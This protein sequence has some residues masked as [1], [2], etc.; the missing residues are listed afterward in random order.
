MSWWKKLLKRSKG[1]GHEPSGGCNH[2]EIHLRQGTAEFEWFVS[3]GELEMRGDLAHGARHLANLLSFD[4][5]NPEWIDLLER[6]LAAGQPDP[7]QLIPRGEKAYYTSEAMRAYLWYRQGRLADACELLVQVTH[8][9]QDSRYLEA[10]ALGWLEPPGV[11]ESLPEELGLMLFS[12]A[13]GRFPEA[14]LSPV[15]R[16]QEIRRWARLCD[17]FAR[18]YPGEGMTGML[19]A[20]LFRKAGYFAEAEALVR[21]ALQRAPDWHLATALGLILRQKGDLSGAEQAFSYALQLD[22]TDMSARLEAGDT[23]FERE[24]W[25]D[26]LCWYENALALDQR[27]EWAYPSALFCRWMLTEDERQ[28]REL[29]DLARK[30]NG[31]AQQ[32]YNQL[33][34]NAL[35]EPADATAN[36]LRQIREMLLKEP[37]KGEGSTMS[38]TVS[39]LEAPSNTLAFRLEMEALQQ[40]LRLDV[41]VEKVAQP[42]P[43][44]SI[45]EIKY[46]LWKYDG[47]DPSP[48]LPPPGPDV[49]R[50]ITELARMPYD[51]DA[52]WAAA[53]HVAEALGPARVAEILA[54]MVHPPAVPEGATALAWL[55]RVQ[56]AA[57]YAAAQVDAG[58]DG[59]VRRE[60]LFSVLLGPQ[61]WSTEAA[62]RALTRIARENETY[63]PAMGEAFQQLADHRP[64]GGYCWWEHTLYQCWLELPHLFP[65]E[66][67]ELQKK[68]K[69]IQAE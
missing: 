59:S 60:A 4:P 52:C 34:F 29:L 57:M 8:A 36:C 50:R 47:T 31:R 45:T 41:K 44:V 26:A 20:G 15:R 38:L 56:H 1:A 61:D 64:R 51:E 48:G 58:W 5:G 16:L 14:R 40:N 25:Q 55:P 68:L 24:R 21:P 27:Q 66:R 30:G 54:V 35:P 49:V 46:L 33:Y 18:V 3:R 63:A 39:G 6:Y 13:L 23:F 32:L 37:G 10:W 11:V 65:G 28:V 2:G 69:E 9:K 53:S 67:E 22:P 19:R 7:E 42:D 43:R 12:L 17:R 62:I